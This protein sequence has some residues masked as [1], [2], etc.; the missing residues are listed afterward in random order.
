MAKL[1]LTDDWWTAPTESSNHRLIM[2]T[3][4]RGLQPAR[5]L[6]IYVYRIEVT[7]PYEPDAAGLP[8]LHTSRLMEQVTE[9]FKADFS[10]DPV[11]ILTGIYTGDGERNYVFYTRSLHIFQKKLNAILS[12]FEL[13]PLSFYAEED[14]Q[15]AEYDEMCQC[16]VTEGE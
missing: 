7:W 16:E 10:R 11:A 6:G 12:P 5:D 9:A 2:V 4:R 13:L 14:P 8:Q 3:G 15:W 1:K